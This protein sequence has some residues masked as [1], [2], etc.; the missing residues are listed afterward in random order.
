MTETLAVHAQSFP[1]MAERFDPV[2]HL[3]V[4][5]V[6]SWLLLTRASGGI[7][8]R[9]GFRFL[10]PKGREG[11]SPSSRT[12]HCIFDNTLGTAGCT[13]VKWVSLV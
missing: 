5:E 6:S 9:A 13:T 2:P 11:S 4:L 1:G 3:T 7:G 10:C 12:T 8:R